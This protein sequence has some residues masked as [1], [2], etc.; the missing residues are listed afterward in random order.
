MLVICAFLYAIKTF[1]MRS[2]C[3]ENAQMLASPYSRFKRES[4]DPEA[5]TRVTEED[6]EIYA[7]AV[8]TQNSE[9]HEVI[10]V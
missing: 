8:S 4:R 10:V 1:V 5:Q 3:D 6:D 9:D 7:D 2:S